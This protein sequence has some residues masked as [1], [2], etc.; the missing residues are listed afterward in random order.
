[1]DA[2]QVQYVK[3]SD[4]YDIA[5]AL[6]G[7]GI[8]VIRVPQVHSHFS[9]QWSS[10]MLDSEFRQWSEHFEM[11][12]FDPRG[13]GLST[14]GLDESTSLTSYERD[15]DAIV[16]K[17][18]LERFILLGISYGGKVAVRYAIAHPERVIA[19]VLWSYTDL[20]FQSPSVKSYRDVAR[21]DWDLFARMVPRLAWPEMDPAVVLAVHREAITQ[22]DYLRV[23]ASLAAESGD[24]ALAN[25]RVPTLLLA[26]RGESRPMSGENQ[27]RHAAALI[28]SARLVS[29]D[30]VRGGMSTLDGTT[31]PAIL[32]VEQFLQDNG[33]GDAPSIAHAASNLS[34]RELE[35]LRLV[36]AGQTNQQIADALVI[37]R[38][39]VRRHVSNVFDKTGIVNRAQ[40]GVYAREHG[41]A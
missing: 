4:G 25:L 11:V 31:P 36:A 6:S 19:L 3:T 8:P 10:G 33:A 38:N 24:T 5:Y 17:L 14:R 13:Q 7:E 20:F 29:F 23:S 27:A 9:L 21:T 2:P 30:D 16:S 37:S 12:L 35:V 15:I 39:T 1:M 41:L 22:S 32:A 40:A 34:A 28:P 26:P 18:G